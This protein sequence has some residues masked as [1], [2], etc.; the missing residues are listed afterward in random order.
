MEFERKRELKTPPKKSNSFVLEG[1]K[2]TAET[3]SGNGA[4][5][6]NTSNDL[7][8]DQFNSI[9]KWLEPRPYREIAADM[10]KLW[11][12]N[13][14]QCLQLTV[15]IR[16]ITRESVVND[17][18]GTEKLEMQVGQGL[19]HEGLMR[20]LW[21]AIHHRN[22]FNANIAYFIA[23]GSWK[24]IFEMLS[25]DLQYHEWFGR[26]LDWDFLTKVILAGLS[27][28][29]TCELVKK[30]LPTIRANNVCTTVERRADNMIGKH[31]AKT[32]FG[33]PENEGDYSTNKKY[34]VL[35]NTG[36][37]HQWQ[38][39]IGSK[40]FLQ[41]D[42]NTIPGRA[43]SL[44]VSSKFLRS[45]GLL[46]KYKQWIGGKVKAKYTGYVYE[47]FTPFGPRNVSQHVDSYQEETINAQFRTLIDNAKQVL[48]AN[49]DNGLL[50]VR[51]ISQSMFSMVPGTQVSSFSVGKAMAL[52]FS[53]LL[54]G[55]FANSYASFSA[56]CELRT[57][58]GITPV[59]KWRNDNEQFY[60][61]D[62]NLQSVANFFAGIKAKGIDEGEFPSGILIISDG[63]FNEEA[64]VS[65]FTA[66]RSNLLA[67]GFSDEYVKNFKLVLWDIPN[68]YYGG[69]KTKFED[70][71]DSPNSF[72]I[73][74]LDPAAI[75]FLL[76]TKKNKHIPRT[77]REL[78][79]AA[80]D[81]ELLNRLVAMR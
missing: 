10:D 22:V 55:A 63:E 50:V 44:L 40:R 64:N 81:Q 31:I 67:A 78:F 24:D 34:R 18:S 53:E 9:S 32:L 8:V 72:Y 36:T 33:I 80:M 52:Y 20:L 77:A 66:F 19:K 57:W 14:K 16:L 37:A 65:N 69:S 62:T 45:Q 56:K 61:Q 7:F 13:P 42:F 46:E 47:L 23:A 68:R 43:L 3:T 5:K 75:A 38:Q 2:A 41:I 70:F 29:R 59:D 1:L 28:P 71:A 30:Y 15:Y 4:V 12:I 17:D 26:K 49:N 51:D 21:V 54:T 25:L 6:Y 48:A 11:R 35:K 39:L 73:S 76:G 74:G 27:N 60:S 79:L 58:K